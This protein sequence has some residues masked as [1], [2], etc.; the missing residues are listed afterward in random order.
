MFTIIC[1]GSTYVKKS[2]VVKD[3]GTQ[4]YF[5]EEE[6]LVFTDAHN[7]VNDLEVAVLD[8][9]IGMEKPIGELL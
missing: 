1:S 7:W 8:K 2:S 5:A 3:G 9:T 6:L 4:P